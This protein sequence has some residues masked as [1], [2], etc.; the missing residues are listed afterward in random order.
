MVTTNLAAS[1]NKETY[2]VE[3]IKRL[4]SLWIYQL[5]KRKLTRAQVDSKLAGV[6]PEQ[7]IIFRQ[8]L[9]YYRELSIATKAKSTSTSTLPNALPPKALPPLWVKNR[10]RLK[11]KNRTY[12]K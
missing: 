6:S 9:N 12:G 4:T 2:H 1:S 10:Q 11:S 7:K 8:W 3:Q 5:D